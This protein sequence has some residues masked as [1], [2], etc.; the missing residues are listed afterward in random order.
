MTVCWQQ[1]LNVIGGCLTVWWPWDRSCFSVSRSQ[2]W[3]TCTDLAFWMIAGWTGSGSGGWCPWW[4]LWPSC[5]NGW[6]RCP[7]GQVVCPR[8]CVVQSSL[9]SGKPYG[10]GWSS[11]LTR[12]W[13]SPPGCS[14]LCICRSLWVLLVT[15]QIS[16]ASWG[17]RGVAEDVDLSEV[18][19][20][21]VYQSVRGID[22]VLLDNTELAFVI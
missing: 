4:S 18:V 15:S 19:C 14:R 20:L 17:W 11:C 1:P 12:R 8:W 7:G 9:P 10:W 21:G 6:C 3:C 16:S 13:Y 5:N 2:L 22:A